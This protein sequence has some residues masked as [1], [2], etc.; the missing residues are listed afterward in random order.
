MAPRGRARGPAA[1]KI[2]GMA[3]F[4]LPEGKRFLIVPEE[5]WP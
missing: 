5:K 3:G 2:A 1:E 4:G